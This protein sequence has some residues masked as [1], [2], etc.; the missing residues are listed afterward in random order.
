MEGS[1]LDT[2]LVP[3]VGHHLTNRDTKD[4]SFLA[5][6]HQPPHLPTSGVR[7]YQGFLPN[8]S[9]G[10]A[11]KARGVR[12]WPPYG[13]YGVILGIIMVVMDH[14]RAPPGVREHAR[15]GSFRK[16]QRDW[17]AIIIFL[18]GLVGIS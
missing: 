17:V 1:A 10:V 4:L 12:E 13:A 2:T 9:R 3:L 6:S 16:E 11:Q 8:T 18:L 7:K 5:T 14:P 15:G